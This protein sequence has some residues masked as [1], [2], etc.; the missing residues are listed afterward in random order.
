MTETFSAIVVDTVDGKQAAAIRQLTTSDLPD[1]AVLVDVAF[2]TVNYKDALAI[3]P[4]SPIPIAQVTP[5]VAGIDLA[6][7]VRESR[8]PAW[9]PGDRVLVNGYGLSERHWGGYAGQARLK[10]EWLVRVPDAFSHEH[11]MALGTAGYTAMLCV[12]AVEDHGV[13]PSD[14]PVL[15]T[16]ASGGVGSVAVMLL[17]QMGYEVVAATGRLETSDAYLTGLG[18]TRLIPRDALARDS[19]P[20]E[21]ETWAAVIDCVGAQTLATA[22]AQT[23]YGGV[24]AMT[25]LAGGVGLSTTVMPFILRNLTLRGIDSVLAPM[26]SRTRAWARLAELVDPTLLASV[27]STVP[28]AKVPEIADKILR[29]T[30]RGRVSVDVSAGRPA[31]R[32]RLPVT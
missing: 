20:L 26:A 24:V 30:I 4:L 11:A 18:A 12:L 28:L 25:G 17:A 29:G 27:Y 7:T 8:D 16:G 9:R 21:S 31:P 3:S 23:R 2:S 6:G 1:E 22:I 10:P 19:K 14:G 13:R 15:V 5:M 32:A